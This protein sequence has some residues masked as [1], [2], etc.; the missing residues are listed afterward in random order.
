MKT[1]FFVLA[2][3]LAI[4]VLS[5]AAAFTPREQVRDTELNAVAW[6]DD[7]VL[8]V[9]IANPSRRS[10]RF[11]V[12]PPKDTR[13]RHDPFDWFSMTIPARGIM[14]KSTSLSPRWD[15]R[16]DGELEKVLISGHDYPRETA[17]PVQKPVAG[18]KVDRYV[19]ESRQTI[20]IDVDLNELMQDRTFHRLV[21]DREY[22]VIGSR[23]RGRIDV[24]SFDGGF[25]HD[26]R[27]NEVV[28]R[29]PS[30]TLQMQAPRLWDVGL[31]TFDLT[32]YDE[33]GRSEVYEGP[34]IL[35]YGA[36]YTFIDETRTHPRFPIRR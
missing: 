20:E 24:T 26:R 29:K 19:A 7:D 6:L 2:A 28:Y 18:M 1:V 11:F 34:M 22:T 23:E 33:R 36:D 27:R 9:A 35:V 8:Y 31:L 32:H 3:L 13:V 14:L 25:E 12:D 30:M 4:S 10:E 21:V 17:V 15:P 5:P 16:W